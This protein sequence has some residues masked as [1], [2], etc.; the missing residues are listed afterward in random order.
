[1]NEILAEPKSFRNLF[2]KCFHGI[3]EFANK[4]ILGRF[5]TLKLFVKIQILF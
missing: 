1:M 4:V 2:P 5:N 3:Q